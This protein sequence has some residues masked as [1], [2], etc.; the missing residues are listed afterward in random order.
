M[1]EEKDVANQA[2]SNPENADSK[3]IEMIK[4]SGILNPSFTLDKIMDLSS[5]VA[6]LVAKPSVHTDTFIHSHFI[7][8]HQD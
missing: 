3:A 2:A 6:G 5:R 4:A 8:I 1:K 7:Y